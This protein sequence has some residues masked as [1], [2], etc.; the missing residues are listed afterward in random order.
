MYYDGYN[1]TAWL[2]A[3]PTSTG[4]AEYAIFDSSQAFY[5]GGQAWQVHGK[6]TIVAGNMGSL[7]PWM[8]S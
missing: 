7:Q 3:Y 4:L 5:K 6:K 2:A 1:N 8:G